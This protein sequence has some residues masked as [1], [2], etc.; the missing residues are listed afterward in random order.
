MWLDVWWVISK[1]RKRIW[2]HLTPNILTETR[3]HSTTQINHL[4]LAWC[5]MG[6]FQAQKR[7]WSYVTPKYPNWDQVSLNNTNKA[8]QSYHCLRRLSIECYICFI[9]VILFQYPGCARVWVGVSAAFLLGEGVRWTDC[10]AVYWN[11]WLWLWVHGSQWTSGYYTSNWQ[12]W[13]HMIY[14]T[15][16]HNRVLMLL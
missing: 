1:H 8:K 16:I 12:V 3:C 4:C 10:E 13:K 11:I 9:S 2:S 14:F 5:L 7:V 6:D 15:D